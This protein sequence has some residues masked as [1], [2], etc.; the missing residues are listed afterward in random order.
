MKVKIFEG[1][2][3]GQSSP[4]ERDNLENTINDW[5]AANPQIEVIDTRMSMSSYPVQE[6]SRQAYKF[7]TVYMILYR[8]GPA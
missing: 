8:E 3:H 4:A 5:L 2:I 7:V 1:H 6:Y